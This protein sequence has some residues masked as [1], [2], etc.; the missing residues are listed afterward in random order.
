MLAL[1]DAR[2]AVGVNV[3]V[4]VKPVPLNT[5]KL[6]LLMVRSLAAKLL[7]GSS[8]KVKVIV[9]VSPIFNVLTLLLIATVGKTVSIN[10]VR[11][12][13]AVLPVLNVAV[14]LMVSPP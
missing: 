3:A 14:A 5:P 1:P 13:S 9:A 4:R 6:P 7:P 12:A 8:L 2:S 10:I 11:V